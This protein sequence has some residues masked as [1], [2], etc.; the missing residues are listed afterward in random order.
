MSNKQSGVSKR[1]DP[2]AQRIRLVHSSE[3]RVNREKTFVERVQFF[4][5]SPKRSLRKLGQSLLLRLDKDR[6]RL[7]NRAQ[8]H[9]H[10]DSIFG[11]QSTNLIAELCPRPNQPAPNAVQHLEMLL[12][13]GLDGDKS[14]MRSRG[15]FADRRRVGRLVLL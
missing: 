7:T 6:Q 10:D 4:L 5:H 9:G 13:D 12:F 3:L 15:C 8:V 14:Q 11:Q 1:R 2:L